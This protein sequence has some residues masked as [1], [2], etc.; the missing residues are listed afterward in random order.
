MGP[1]YIAAF[2]RYLKELREQ[3]L[4]L[5]RAG[6]VARMSLMKPA[7][8]PHPIYFYNPIPPD[9]GG[10]WS[11]PAEL[12][13]F[14]IRL[15]SDYKP[16]YVAITSLE[17]EAAERLSHIQGLSG[18]EKAAADQYVEFTDQLKKDYDLVKQFGSPA[19]TVEDMLYVQPQVF[20]WKRKT[21][22]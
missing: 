3:Q 7:A 11:P 21:S 4:P 10:A 12:H 2:Q 6:L 14:D 5:D 13:D 15:L 16:T 22:S 1:G 20:V 19:P 9:L 8:V 18:E 17:A